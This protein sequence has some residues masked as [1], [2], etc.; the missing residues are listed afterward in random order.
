MRNKTAAATTMTQSESS[1]AVIAA[2]QLRR[3]QPWP[4]YTQHTSTKFPDAFLKLSILM[5]GLMRTYRRTWPLV[6][7][8]LNIVNFEATGSHV[9]V[10][11]ATNLNVRC[12][13]KDVSAYRCPAKWQAISASKYAREIQ[14]VY[15]PYLI[16]IVNDSGNSF[17]DRVRSVLRNFW[18]AVKDSSII[19]ALRPDVVFNRAPPSLASFCSTYPGL[20]L[21]TG[22]V[23]RKEFFHDRDIDWG[24][25]ACDPKLLALHIILPRQ[26][27]RI[28]GSC[29]VSWPGCPL[30][31]P[32][33][34][35]GF[36][37]SWGAEACRAN[38]TGWKRTMC[39]KVVF[40]RKLG[41]RFGSLDHLNVHLHILRGKVG[42]SHHSKTN[43]NSLRI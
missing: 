14:A 8:A 43:S 29:A 36:N 25:F 41:V 10:V 7:S 5:C 28:G 35:R 21:L 17:G 33:L 11:V 9:L 24:V 31:P 32:P 6:K 38:L 26:I 20:S 16:A 3:I 2:D 23:V 1:D 18:A 15:A 27:S 40:F 22:D 19:L 34:P 13:G 37:G 42:S 39:S 12:S 4:Y 30:T